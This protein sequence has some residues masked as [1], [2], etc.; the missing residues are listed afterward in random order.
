MRVKLA[1]VTTAAFLLFAGQ[2]AA[3]T[4]VGNVG[5]LMDFTD[6]GFFSGTVSTG[7]Q[8]ITGIFGGSGFQ[9]TASGALN[10][11]ETD[12]SGACP[13]VLACNQDGV[14]VLDDE[15]TLLKAKSEQIT[16]DFLGV[17]KF[18]DK[19]YLFDLFWKNDANFEV[20]QING[21]Q[22]AATAALG[23]SGLRII[24][25][26]KSV[27]K[28]TFTAPAIANNGYDNGDNDYAIAA[29]STVPLPA[30]AL[31]LLGA[32]GGLGAVGRRRRTVATA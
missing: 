27:T 32:L 5:N 28:L 29:I 8:P 26:N 17:S 7:Q 20:A 16:I 9:I 3:A 10:F 15:I 30:S 23:T 22:Y 2:A 31:L 4:Y 24:D 19:I 14:G 12:I 13:S 25:F 11:S 21:M 6:S 1:T 18:I